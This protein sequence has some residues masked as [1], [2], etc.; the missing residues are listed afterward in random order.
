M[1]EL[2]NRQKIVLTLIAH[3]HINTAGPIGSKLLVERFNIGLS[4]ATIRN[5][6]SVLTD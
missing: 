6:M 2:T 4:S 3:E 1:D 5:E